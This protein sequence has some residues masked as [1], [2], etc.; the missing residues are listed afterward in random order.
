MPRMS[1]HACYHRRDTMRPAN[2]LL[3]LT[4]AGLALGSWASNEPGRKLLG[5]FLSFSTA[6]RAVAAVATST[7]P[8]S[9]PPRAETSSPILLCHPS[10]PSL[11][12]PLALPDLPAPRPTF[13]TQAAQAH[14]HP[15]P[16]GDSDHPDYPVGERPPK[17]K[18][19]AAPPPVAGA[20]PSAAGL[21]MCRC[22]PLGGGVGTLPPTPYQTGHARDSPAA[23]TCTLFPPRGPLSL[24]PSAGV[25]LHQR[26]R[27]QVLLCWKD[28]GQML[29]RE[30]CP[31]LV[32]RAVLGRSLH[33]GHL[34]LPLGISARLHITSQ[35][36]PCAGPPPELNDSQVP[37]NPIPRQP[38][39]PHNC[40]DAP[41]PSTP[42]A[43]VFDA[44]FLG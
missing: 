27:Q 34:R 17:A 32:C 24:Q 19:R 29:G 11:P 2:F 35:R 43:L 9:M 1:C 20:T 42:A 14:H 38:L 26:H 40:C 15:Y 5:I 18:D 16:S 21:S 33:W 30:H 7:L 23:S 44:A 8:A 12:S 22:P 6:L 41:R 10:C 39:T 25:H 3:L 31:P 13:P 36:W 37:Q 4:C 28:Q